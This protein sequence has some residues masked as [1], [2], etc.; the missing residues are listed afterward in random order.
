MKVIHGG[1]MHFYL[2]GGLKN[3]RMDA[4]PH[5]IEREPLNLCVKRLEDIDFGGTL[6]AF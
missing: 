1:I 6:I 2:H 3:P 5:R 4:I